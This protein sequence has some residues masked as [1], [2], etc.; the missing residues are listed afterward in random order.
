MVSRDL[1]A[2]ITHPNLAHHLLHSLSQTPVLGTGKAGAQFR[3]L[4]PFLLLKTCLSSW[5]PSVWRDWE[6]LELSLLLLPL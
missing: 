4:S 2:G 3:H 1:Q 5:Y 6:L